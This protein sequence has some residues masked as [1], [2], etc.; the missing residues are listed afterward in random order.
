MNTWPYEGRR[1]DGRLTRPRTCH[2]ARL[3]KSELNATWHPN[4][5][6]TTEGIATRIV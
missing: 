4:V 1:V 2:T 6:P 5:I 3:M